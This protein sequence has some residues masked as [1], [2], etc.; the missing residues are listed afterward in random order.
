M[1]K[2]FKILGC[3]FCLIAV[4]GAA[5][6]F[7]VRF[8]G[9]LKA[10]YP[11]YDNIHEMSSVADLIVVGK[12]ISSGDV[13]KLNVNKSKEK[14]SDDD[15]IVYTVSEIEVDS[16]LM[17]DVE[18]GDILKVKQLGDYRMSPLSSLKRID[19]YFEKDTTQLLF[20]KAFETSPYSVVN[21]EQGAMRVNAD[22]TLY[23]K[24]E[25]AFFKSTSKNA[26]GFVTLQEAVVEIQEALAEL[27]AAE[28]KCE[29]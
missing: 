4:F 20:L 12:V 3:V 16:V 13:Q 21:V 14:A 8:S 11:M 15:Y 17:G 22:G 18:E 2:R 7:G 1:N 10:E 23:S 9:T 6:F 24:S 26:T 28:V 19:G 27:K 5:T 25:Y 29:E